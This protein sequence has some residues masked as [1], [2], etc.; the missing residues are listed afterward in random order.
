MFF[1][2]YLAQMGD[3]TQLLTLL[4]ATRIRDHVM[5]FL[6][7]ITGFAVGVGL[8]VTV[9]AGISELIPHR[10]L[11]IISATVFIVLGILIIRKSRQSIKKYKKKHFHHQFL[12][13]ALIIFLTDFGDKTQ[14]AIAL[15]SASYHPLL[16]FLA[17]ILALGLDTFIMIYFSK[18]IL[19]K[20]REKTIEKIAGILFILTGVFLYF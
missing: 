19:H 1:S 8:A 5:L 18:V 7:I 9:G 3:K 6:A 17:G 4:L 11:K 2:L 15:F 14:I 13:T 10:T 12:S 16:V 20:I